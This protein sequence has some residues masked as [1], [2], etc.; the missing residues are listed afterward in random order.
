MIIE[1]LQEI[2]QNTYTIVLAVIA[3]AFIV[4]LVLRRIITLAVHRRISRHKN[5]TA[6]DAR[7]RAETLGGVFRTLSAIIIWITA[8]LVILSIFEVDI[9]ALMT[10]AGLIGIIVGFGAQSTIKDILAGLFIISENQYRVGD[11]VRLNGGGGEVAGVVE[12]LT[13]RITKLR[14]LDGNLH[15]VRNGNADIVSNFTFNHANVNLN[16]SVA[17][18]SDID[19]VEKV[20]NDTGAKM[21]DEPEWADAIRKPIQFLRVDDFADSAI[22]IKTLGEVEPAEQWAVAGEFRRRIKKAF[23]K[24]GISIPF[25]QIVIHEAHKK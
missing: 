22:M 20:I 15:I 19:V 12:E 18:D 16:L 10:G 17:Y 24:A 23:E 9:A 11:I 8:I 7:K 25:P 21:A 3:A 2:F 1:I 4:Q 13:V 5:V 14:D 6:A